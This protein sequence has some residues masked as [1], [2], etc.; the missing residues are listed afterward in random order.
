MGRSHGLTKVELIIAIF[1]LALLAALLLPRLLVEP[2][3]P[4]RR[5][6]CQN[7]LKQLGLVFKMYSHE[8]QGGLFPPMHA[9]AAPLV[10]CSLP[11]RPEVKK[12]G[13]L[14]A[15]PQASAV[16]PEFISDPLI[17]ICVTE[18]RFQDL[19]GPEGPIHLPAV[20]EPCADPMRGVQLLGLSYAYL[21]WHFDRAECGD[22]LLQFSDMVGPRQMT[23]SLS[24]LMAPWRANSALPSDVAAFD[25]DLQTLSDGQGNQGKGTTIRRLQEGLGRF[26]ITDTNN[27]QAGAEA[28]AKVWVMWDRPRGQP[29]SDPNA[30]ASRYVHQP[31]GSNVLYLDSHVEF[32]PY[33]PC[34][35][36]S[37]KAADTAPVNFGVTP[38]LLTAFPR[39]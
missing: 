20:L 4:R 26:L 14:A 35:S 30:L 12:G 37:G 36:P 29:S 28:E 21:G 31:A 1:L 3:G 16:I 24:V 27:S 22:P 10:D 2:P 11:A 39:E 13:F 17:M 19:T 33:A 5:V 18:P 8:S 15:T 38:F 32:K 7:S 23:E 25:A 9:T 34:A 6:S